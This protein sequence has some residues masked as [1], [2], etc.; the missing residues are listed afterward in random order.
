[1]KWIKEP[2]GVEKLSQH[3]VRIYGRPDA[4]GL[5]IASDG[6]TGTA[7]APS[8]AALSQKTIALISLH[9]I[10]RLLEQQY[11]SVEMLNTK[12]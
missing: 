8:R 1:M 10:V 2:T 9:E 12:V 6:Y 5:F 7:I 11:D 3:L 4:R